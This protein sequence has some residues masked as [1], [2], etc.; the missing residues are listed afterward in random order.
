MLWHE[1]V[2]GC[3]AGDGTERSGVWTCRIVVC[4]AARVPFSSSSGVRI[5][6]NAVSRAL[7]AAEPAAPLEKNLSQDFRNQRSMHHS[8]CKNHTFQGAGDVCVNVTDMA[9]Y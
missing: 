5:F 9:M 8:R 7:A 4:Q 2:H 3:E 1:V 6:R